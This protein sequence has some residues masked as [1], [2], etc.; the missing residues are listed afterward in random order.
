MTIVSTSQDHHQVI[1]KNY[2]KLKKHAI[3]VIITLC[4][5]YLKPYCMGRKTVFFFQR[6]FNLHTKMSAL[7]RLGRHGTLKSRALWS[8]RDGKGLSYT[9]QQRFPNFFQVGTTFISQNVLRTTLLSSPLTANCLRFSTTVCDTQFTLIL[10][11]LSF[12]D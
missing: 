12:L 5:S 4:W 1:I 8:V 10:F 6:A 9:L 7:E 11:F 2:M 3:Q